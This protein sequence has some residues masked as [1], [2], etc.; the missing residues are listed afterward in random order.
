MIKVLS[1]GIF[2][3]IQDFGR[4]GFQ[5]YGVPYSGVMDQKAAS[6]A[7]AIL[8]N[9]KDLPVLEITMQGPKLQFDRD[10]SIC[11]SGADLSA[12]LNSHPVLNN[13]PVS[14]KE[15][16]MLSFGKL[17]KGFRAYLAVSGG[18]KTEQVMQS[19]SMYQGI[20]AKSKL[21]K[22]DV[23][24]I[25]S[26]NEFR[27]NKHA[28]IKVNDGYFNSKTIEVFKGPEFDALSDH[29]KEYLLNQEFTISKDNNRM[30]YQLNEMLENNLE[31]VITSLVLPGTVQLTPSGKLIVLMRD[32][33]TTGGY[34]RVLQLRESAINVLAQKFTGQMVSF[35]LD[36][37]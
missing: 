18:F 25:E 37:Y 16:D 21:E 5:K 9:K 15:G 29:Q 23:L 13:K 11:I 35:G 7:N 34:P 24:E 27:E 30:A 10:T 1:A 31:P 28:I 19:F 3:T 8:G 2:S 12:K 14:I 33:Q 17:T 26:Q 22:H 4:V 36:M 20:T 6:F 32:C